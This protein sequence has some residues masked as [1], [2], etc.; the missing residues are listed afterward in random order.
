MSSEK[1]KRLAKN[2]LLLY[3]R[4]LFSIVISLYTSRV[5]LQTLGIED[6]GIYN[7]VGGVTTTVGNIAI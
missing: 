5:V 4:Q 2:T 6:Y 1:N 7:V 3:I